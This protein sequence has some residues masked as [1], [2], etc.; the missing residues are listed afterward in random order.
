[1][2]LIYALGGGLGHL[3]RG[4]A[5]AR[6]AERAGEQ[7]RLITNSPFAGLVPLSDEL[8]GEC[9]V[10]DAGAERDEVTARVHAELERRDF[11][12]L[13]VDTFP[14]G[15]AGELADVD[16]GVPRA[17]VHRDLSPVYCEKFNLREVV[18]SYDLVL[19]PGERGPLADDRAIETAPWLVRDAGELVSPNEARSDL[20]VDDDRPV[21]GVVASGNAAEVEEAEERAA[22]LGAHACVRLL[23]L[24]GYWPLIRLLPGVDLLVGSGGYNTVYEARAVGVPLLATPRERLYDRQERRLR[25]EEH[26][27]PDELAE[28]AGELRRRESR[29][30]VYNNG[31]HAA[32][33]ALQA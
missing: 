31:V 20:G 22:S 10:I 30:P 12:L 11:D 19:S 16:V 2:W 8:D 7:V 18:H 28:R 14:R 9:V 3:V 17:L 6:A 29:T 32:V 15:L 21:V 25:P 26:V 4:L 33:A 24:P 13:V 23:A 27:E 1:M 5:L